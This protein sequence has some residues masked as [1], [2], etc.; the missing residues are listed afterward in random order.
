[1]FWEA[2]FQNGREEAFTI[3]DK[4]LHAIEVWERRGLRSSAQAD[5][6]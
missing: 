1:M 3:L 2:R 6:H 4:P 5:A